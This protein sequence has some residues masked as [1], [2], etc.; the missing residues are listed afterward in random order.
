MGGLKSWCPPGWV[1]IPEDLRA[2]GA[3]PTTHLLKIDKKLYCF[4]YMRI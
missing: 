2:G 1:N 3:I 4:Y